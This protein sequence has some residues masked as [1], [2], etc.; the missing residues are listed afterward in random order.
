MI[1]DHLMKGVALVISTLL[2]LVLVHGARTTV[3]PV[4][5][6]VEVGDV[7]LGLVVTSK[8]P[9]VT[10][11]LSGP[12]LGYL[13]VTRRNIRA[14]LSLAG[15]SAGTHRVVITAA[16]VILPPGLVL[17]RSRPEAVV[18]D[19]APAGQKLE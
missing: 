1:R 7:P 9:A 16:D 18:V 10:L 14:R 12:R 17:R 11:I 4:E 3:R 15:A 5:A 6:K 2:W 13:L 8:R 19:L